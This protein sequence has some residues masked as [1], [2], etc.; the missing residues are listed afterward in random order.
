MWGSGEAQGRDPRDSCKNGRCVVWACRRRQPALGARILV[1]VLGVRWRQL[2][3]VLGVL[4]A[5]GLHGGAVAL[6][7]GAIDLHG[8]AVVLHRGAARRHTGELG[9]RFPLE[10]IVAGGP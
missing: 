10:C 6:H 4:G 5:V 1:L 8:G 3:D 9:H 2:A 7:R